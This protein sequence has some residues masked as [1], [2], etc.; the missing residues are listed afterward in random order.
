MCLTSHALGRLG[1][2]GTTAFRGTS[3]IT[4][5]VFERWHAR[6]PDWQAIEHADAY[7]GEP[8]I[9]IPLVRVAEYGVGPVWFVR[10]PDTNFHDDMSQRMDKRVDGSLGGSL[11]RYCSVTV[12]YPRAMAYFSRHERRG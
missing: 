4:K 2:G 8:M 7:L 3:F 5:T 9:R 11:L 10:R 12:D 6:H 1:D